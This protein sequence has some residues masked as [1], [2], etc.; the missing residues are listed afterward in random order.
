MSEWLYRQTR[1]ADS[2]AHG[3]IQKIGAIS[4]DTTPMGI[5]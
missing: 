2:F 1:V 4:L 3:R 5:N